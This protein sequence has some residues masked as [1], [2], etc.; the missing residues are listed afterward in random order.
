MSIKARM[1]YEIHSTVCL[2][3]HYVFVKVYFFS[4][5]DMKDRYKK[6]AVL[7]NILNISATSQLNHNLKAKSGGNIDV[8]SNK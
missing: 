5:K 4:E 1:S 3:L 8:T 7:L 2:E 6:E